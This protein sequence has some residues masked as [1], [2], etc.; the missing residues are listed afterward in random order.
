MSGY[1]LI[2]G[3]EAPSPSAAVERP[4]DGRSGKR[5]AYKKL[6]AEEVDGEAKRLAAAI[7]EVLAGGRTPTEAA[8]ALG[9]SPPRYYALEERALRGLVAACRRRPRGRV[10]TSEGEAEK[11][12]AEVRRLERECG[13]WQALLRAAQR[14]VGLAAPQPSKPTAGRKRRPR[15]SRVARALRA[16]KALQSEG[17]AKPAEETLEKGGGSGEDAAPVVK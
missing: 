15:R 13:R 1:V 4:K 10:R 7:L 17:K 16:A 14:T 6:G 5:V 11:L 8:V 9:I 3:K 2:T 12:R